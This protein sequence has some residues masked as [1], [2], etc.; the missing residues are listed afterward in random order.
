M[1]LWILKYGNFH[2]LSAQT[3]KPLVENKSLQGKNNLGD[4]V[5]WYANFVGSWSQRSD[6]ELDEAYLVY[7]FQGIHRVH[8]VY[9]EGIAWPSGD[10][11]FLFDCWKKAQTS[12]IVFPTQE[13]SLSFH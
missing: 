8:V 12:E 10:T 7:F 4:Y 5:Q 9:I 3:E 6:S 1:E 13:N 2:E 11:E